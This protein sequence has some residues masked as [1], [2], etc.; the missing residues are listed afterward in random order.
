LIQRENYSQA[1]EPQGTVGSTANSLDPTELENY[2]RIIYYLQKLSG[3]IGPGPETTNNFVD[4]AINAAFLKGLESFG[5]NPS[6]FGQISSNGQWSSL[7]SDKTVDNTNMTMDNGKG[8]QFGA[9]PEAAV[10]PD[11]SSLQ[12]KSGSNL[13]AE[14]AGQSDPHLGRQVASNH[15]S[16][17]APN[18]DPSSGINRIL[19]AEN[20][21]EGDPVRIWAQIVEGLKKQNIKPSEVKQ[22]S[23]QLRP[24]ELGEVKIS[25]KVEDG[26]VHLTMTATEQA[27]SSILQNSIPELR[28]GLSQAGIP[29]GD[30]EMGSHSDNQKPAENR[31]NGQH[32]S[33]DGPK[34][35]EGKDHNHLPVGISYFPPSLSGSRINLSA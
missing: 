11:K 26:R 35:E 16:L 18:P 29:C 17:S 8:N 21:G 9:Q 28:N 32:N 10:L 24:A 2:I 19:N 14:H 34:S 20:P 4:R 1:F 27:T 30:L 3:K 31:E 6:E 22:L 13:K 15:T 12:S 7:T 33:S 5:N 25:L 23:I